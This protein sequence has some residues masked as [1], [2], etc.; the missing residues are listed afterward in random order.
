[1]EKKYLGIFEKFFDC[2]LMYMMSLIYS[3]LD[4]S[5]F[6][7]TLSDVI[8]FSLSCSPQSCQTAINLG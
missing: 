4:L 1:M 7:V 2:T 5:S 8:R 3:L 6:M